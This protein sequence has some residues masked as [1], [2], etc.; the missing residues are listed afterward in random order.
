M[1]SWFVW[2]LELS[3]RQ[4]ISQM[5]LLLMVRVIVAAALYYIVL[6]LLHV[7]I[8]DECVAFVRGKITI[9]H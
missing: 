4:G 6:R 1:K 8:L 3:V 9:E 5:W 7:K 2:E